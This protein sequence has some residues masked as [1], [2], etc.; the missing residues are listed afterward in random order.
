MITTNCMLLPAIS[1]IGLQR[2]ER[3]IRF[4]GHSDELK[5]LLG[6]ALSVKRADFFLA[7][8]P[9]EGR[10]TEA[11]VKWFDDF[12]EELGPQAL[13]RLEYKR[14]MQL[15]TTYISCWHRLSAT[16][17]LVDLANEYCRGTFRCAVTTSVEQVLS[18]FPIPPIPLVP[19]MT[20]EFFPVRYLADESRRLRDALEGAWP[21]SLHPELEFK[22][23]D[24]DYEQEARFV[25][26]DPSRPGMDAR[27]F[28]AIDSK[29]FI[30][31]VYSLDSCS[32]TQ[33]ETVLAGAVWRPTVELCP[34]DR[35]LDLC[36]S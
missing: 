26:N 2:E 17:N 7:G 4:I 33:V 18:S 3:L 31:R 28:V 19:P 13:Q 29:T 1:G 23:K 32:N 9:Q 34:P 22:R 15:Q 16:S 14:Q 27:R 20:L 5:H 8:D 36:L 24:F 35:L 11:D 10:I 25:L 12:F 21:H 6:G 30:T